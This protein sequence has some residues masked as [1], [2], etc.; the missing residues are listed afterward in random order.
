M[1]PRLPQATSSTWLC[2]VYLGGYAA[3]RLRDYLTACPLG[4][5]AARLR[6][7]RLCGYVST[8]QSAYAPTRQRGFAARLQGGYAT[9]RQGGYGATRVRE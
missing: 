5:V 3:T 7:T 1:A 8:R 6:A 9:T 2:T 4:Y